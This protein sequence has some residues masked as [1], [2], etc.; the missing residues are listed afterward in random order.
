MNHKPVALITGS[1]RGIGRETAFEFARRGYDLGLLDV[2]QGELQATSREATDLGA[3]CVAETCDLSSLEAAQASLH[4]VARHFGRLDVL[5]NNA[6]W[7]EIKTMR[8]ISVESW[9]RTIRICLTAPA[10]LARWS[11]EIMEPQGSGVII[12]VCSI[13]S[14]RGGGVAAAYPAVKGGLDSL[15]Y[16]LAS[17]YGRSGIRVLAVSPGAIDTDLSADYPGGNGQSLEPQLRQWS[18]GEIPLGRWGQPAEI[19]RVIAMLS[20]DDASYM[21]GTNV[22]VDGGWSRAHFPREL[23]KQMK[24]D[25]F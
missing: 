24:P 6:A 12:N 18:T 2:L 25:Q 8:E 11:A 23:L 9:E 21:T 19:A 13:M 3:E 5:V 15:T 10:F 4:R 14:R 20:S 1:A 17:L 7:R 16:E 22:T